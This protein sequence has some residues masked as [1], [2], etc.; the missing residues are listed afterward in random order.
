MSNTKKYL[1]TSDEFSYLFDLTKF[2]IYTNFDPFKYDS[3]FKHLFHS[4]KSHVFIN[5]YL[6]SKN[7][8]G[9]MFLTKHQNCYVLTFYFQFNFNYELFQFYKE[10]YGIVRYT[11]SAYR[12]DD[13]VIPSDLRIRLH[14][15]GINDAEIRRQG[16][17]LFFKRLNEIKV[18]IQKHL[19]EELKLEIKRKYLNTSF[20]HVEA[21]DDIITA[22]RFEMS[23]DPK[24]VESF[25]QVDDWKYRPEKSDPVEGDSFSYISGGTK[26][27]KWLTGEW[28]D[29]VK[30]KQYL[31]ESGKE[32]AINR[33]ESKYT[34]K[35]RIRAIFKS[36]ASLKNDS[37]VIQ[38]KRDFIAKMNA[39]GK[40]A[41]A[42]HL[43]IYNIESSEGSKN[44]FK[45]L[46]NFCQSLIGGDWY[47]IYTAFKKD[48]CIYT[49][50]KA[51]ASY[52]GAIRK[53]LELA[54]ARKLVKRKYPRG[55]GGVYV[56]D[57]KWIYKNKA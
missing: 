15:D 49:G 34:D 37:I 32:G 16:Y 42:R 5:P 47:S 21:C 31:K 4:K 22:P 35:K 30:E 6:V 36:C 54:A 46:R 39:L 44:K 45:L 29:G 18:G 19:H 56:P 27:R 7:S 2:T 43:K 10:F 52:R 55:R 12:H 3:W 51:A 20:Q 14:N 28:A 25:E 23:E 17:K 11:L 50:T 1:T 57:W 9:K 24:V 8:D 38:S 33:S 40:D 48:G 13:N 53:V 26:Q 41:F